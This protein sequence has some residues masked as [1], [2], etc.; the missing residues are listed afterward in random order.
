MRTTITINDKV[1]KALKLHAARGDETMSKIIE[2]AVKYKILEDLEDAQA[3]SHESTH[4][5]ED[6]VREFRAEGLL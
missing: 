5:F 4:S 3:R 2:D 1:Y 6:L